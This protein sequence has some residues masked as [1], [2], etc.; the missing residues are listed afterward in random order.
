MGKYDSLAIYEILLKGD[1]FGEMVSDTEGKVNG[2]KTFVIYTS[3]VKGFMEAVNNYSQDVATVL[4]KSK[5][6]AEGGTAD[7]EV[8]VALLKSIVN[9]EKY[10]EGTVL[11][12]LR[13][14]TIQT[15]LKKLGE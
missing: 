8:I 4:E 7:K 10:A 6:G 2:G 12:R 13:D 3:A 5:E 15:L 11:E 14:G 1:T 9:T